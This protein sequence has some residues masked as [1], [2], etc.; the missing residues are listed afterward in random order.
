MSSR[1]FSRCSSKEGESFSSFRAPFHHSQFFQ[2]LNT[3][4]PKIRTN[5]VGTHTAAAAAAAAG[6]SPWPARA[7]RTR[8]VQVG[9]IIRGE[10][11]GKMPNWGPQVA[12]VST[13]GPAASSNDKKE[14]YL[15]N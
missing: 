15:Q 12:L 9:A 2:G 7:A 13:A 3:K 11:G 10:F 8:S 1:Y 5:T 14:N 4:T 6:R